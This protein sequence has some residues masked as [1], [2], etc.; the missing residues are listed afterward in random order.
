MSKLIFNK[1]T[2][3]ANDLVT[4]TIFG[5]GVL[6]VFIPLSECIESIISHLFL[7]EDKS[8]V[9]Q[10][11]DMPYKDAH[12]FFPTDYDRCNPITKSEAT[13]KFLDEISRSPFFNPQIPSTSKT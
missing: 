13:K 2:F 10:N 8:S 12:S 11:L 1:I 5:L 7:F 9:E 4:W 6:S 3:Q